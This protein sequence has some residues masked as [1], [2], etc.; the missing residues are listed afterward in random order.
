MKYL[1]ILMLCMS[2]SFFSSAEDARDSKSPYGVLAFL[3]FNHEWNNYHYDTPEKIEKALTMME[4]AG[5]GFVRMT[6]EWNDIEPE[7]GK[8]EFEKYDHLVE[9]LARHRLRVLGILAFNAPWAESWNAAPDPKQFAAYAANVVGRYKSRIKYWEIWNEPD[10]AQYWVPQDNMVA[11]AQLLKTVYPVLKKE[12]PTCLVVAG[13]FAK[14]PFS[15]KRVYRN[16]A[17]DSFDIVSIHPFVNPELPNAMK[18]LKG[19]HDATL[20]VMQANGDGKKKIWFTELGCPGITAANKGKGWFLGKSPSPAKQA[21]WVKDVYSAPLT[22]PGLEKIF[23]AFFRD[24]DD[25]FKD[26]TDQFG[27]VEN[28]FSPKPAYNAYKD[29]ARRNK[30]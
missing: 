10:L 18:I 17:G 8:F 25:H 21:A 30:R 13:G 20:R 29:V 6:F 4:Q 14:I 22:W 19:M 26:D 3:D 12:D 9:A 23:W 24:T 28:D 15:L 11:Y 1:S 7:P 27:L 16:G 2:M 5:V